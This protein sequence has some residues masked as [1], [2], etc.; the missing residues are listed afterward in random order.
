MRSV[1]PGADS[2]NH[3]FEKNANIFYKRALNEPLLDI[4]SPRNN[5]R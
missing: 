3:I 5:G 2:S 4:K 1:K